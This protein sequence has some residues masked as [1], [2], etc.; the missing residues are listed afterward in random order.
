MSGNLP[1]RASVVVVG[2]GI[3]G[4][5]C[6]FYLTTFGVRDILVLDAGY[7]QGGASGRNGT[8]IRP[9]FASNEWTRLFSLSCQEW[10]TLSSKIE[11]NVMFTRRGYTMVAEKEATSSMLRGALDVHKECKLGS[12]FVPSSRISEHLPAIDAH[13]VNSALH[14]PEGGVAPHHAAM[15]G[16]Y[17]ACSRRGVDIRYRTA[18]TGFER[19]QGRV[20]GVYVGDHCVSADTVLLAGG[21]H[22]NAL[23]E[24]AGVTLD[25]F[26][27]RLEA[28]ALEPMRP[29]IKPALAL[30]DSLCYLHQTSR[31]EIVG[32]AEVPERPQVTLHS[33]L[34]VMSATAAVYARMFP[35]LGNVRI[36][37]HWAG[38]IHISPDFGP[39][40]GEH[41]D[42]H[43]LWISA[44]WS[45]GFAGAPG[46]G[47]LLARAIAKGEIDDRMRPFAV[48]RFRRGRPIA[49]AGIVLAKELVEMDET[50]QPATLSPSAEGRK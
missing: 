34:P 39:V 24:L 36:L 27:M 5:C 45:Y 30:V 16:L 21:G 47:L 7:W 23:A 49:E 31:G 42:L 12:Y 14:L 19:Q 29:F 8:L 6:A 2:G 25:G 15:K 32:G 26:P 18:V 40:I 44:G 37:R 28:M 41:P 43:G 46:A 38:M 33:D 17:A 48:D 20:F 3:Q 1:K 4:L 10:N 50:E 35:R 11:E 22:S 13:Q 9:G